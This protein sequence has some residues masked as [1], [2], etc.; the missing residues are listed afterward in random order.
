VA[1][2]R[3]KSIFDQAKKKELDWVEKDLDGFV[4]VEESE[5]FF[6]NFRLLIF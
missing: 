4:L 6:M 1:E 2:A 5:L 3:A